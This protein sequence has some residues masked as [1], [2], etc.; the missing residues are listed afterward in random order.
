MVMLAMIFFLALRSRGARALS[1]RGYHAFSLLSLAAIY[2]YVLLFD[3]WQMTPQNTRMLVPLYAHLLFWSIVA[4]REALRF[5][6]RAGTATRTLCAAGV[7]SLLKIPA[8]VAVLGGAA[9]RTGSAWE[10][11]RL[12]TRLDGNDD[13]RTALD[14]ALVPLRRERG[15]RLEVAFV[16]VPTDEYLKFW[17]AP[18]LYDARTV[19]G[20]GTLLAAADVVVAPEGA[21]IPSFVR[22][23]RIVLPGGLVRDI[24]TR[25]RQS[26]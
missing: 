19:A 4:W 24:L 25:E 2:G 11:L 16:E 6:G 10:P 20:D 15:T 8:I 22:R 14:R 13:W 7:L 26:P 18:F 23:E 9:P 3:P 21:R 5:D 17:V 12:T 1:F